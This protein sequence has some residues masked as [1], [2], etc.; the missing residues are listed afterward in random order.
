MTNLNQQRQ[1]IIKAKC[2]SS[3]NCPSGTGCTNGTCFPSNS[4]ASQIW[5]SAWTPTGPKW[6]PGITGSTGSFNMYSDQAQNNY[7]V[8]RSYNLL[9]NYLFQ[10]KNSIDICL[11]ISNFIDK[12]LSPKF[13]EKYT[14]LDAHIHSFETF[15]LKLTLNGKL[16][17]TD[18][19]HL[20]EILHSSD[21]DAV[22]LGKQILLSYNVENLLDILHNS[23]K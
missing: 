13:L 12:S 21:Q 22:A 10:E 14:I 3:S 1:A 6:V 17:E 11:S 20:H 15:L 9:Y 8:H 7:E 18:A 16:P 2:G 4:T 5:N 23:K 19:F